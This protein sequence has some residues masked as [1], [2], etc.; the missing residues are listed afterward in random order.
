MNFINQLMRF[1]VLMLILI[2]AIGT[3]AGM[4]KNL[5]LNLKV[6]IAYIA[7]VY[8]YWNVMLEDTYCR[9]GN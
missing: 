6:D 3:Y 1:S 9:K 5:L 2:V 8:V 7:G 4:D